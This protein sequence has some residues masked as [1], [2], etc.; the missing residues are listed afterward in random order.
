MTHPSGPDFEV[1]FRTA[2]AGLVI[3]AADDTIVDVNDWFPRWSGLSREELLGTP[4][5]RL[6]SV[7]D[8]VLLSTRTALLV[9]LTGHVPE[10]AVTVLGAD[11]ARLPATLGA[12]RVM[13]DPPFTLFVVA[14]RREQSFEEAQL[15]T[16][17]RRADDSDARRKAAEDDLE[18]VARRDTLTGLLNRSGVVEAVAERV[19]ALRPGETVG[20]SWIGLDHFRVV[21]ESLGSAAGDDVLMTIS[22]RLAARFGDDALLGRVGGDEF[23]VVLPDVPSD[24]VADEILALVAEPVVADDVEIVVSASIG[25]ASRQ[26][27]QPLGP[28]GALDVAEALLHHAG[29]GMYAAKAAGRSRWKRLDADDDESALD[30]IRL[31]GEVRTAIAQSQLFLDY[32]PQLDLRSGRLHGLEALVRWQHPERGLIPPAGFIDA[33]EK[34]GLISQIGLWACATAI[35]KAADLASGPLG[36]V[37]MSVN[38]A[39]RQFG[40]ARFADSVVALLRAADLDPRLLTL[41]LT[42]TGLVTDGPQIAETFRQLHEHGVKLSIDDFGTGHASFAYLRDFPVDE[43]KIDQSYVERIDSSAESAALVVGC[44]DLAHALS[45]SVVAEG[46]ETVAQLSRLTEIGCDVVQGYLYS[47]PLGDEALDAWIAGRHGT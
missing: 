46:V 38:I 25:L 30:E 35:A 32:Q 28:R 39:A 6:L 9:E 41:E 44:V 23:V 2:G 17:V 4:F 20:A 29:N 5:M 22:S 33:A 14:P 26:R 3:T 45:V 24:A 16:A 18:Q 1:V 43:I 40:E 27:P 10:F 37:Q 11:R 34:S 21:V 36:P 12:S 7:A 31:L 8:R 19:V 47:R 13:T 15:I 42:E